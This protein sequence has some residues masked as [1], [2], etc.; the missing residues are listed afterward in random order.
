MAK[1][2]NLTS[3]A[4]SGLLQDEE[5]TRQATLQNRE[6]I[7]FLL[8]LHNHKCEEFEGLCCMNLTSKAGDVQKVIDQM[9]DMIKDIKRETGDWLENIFTSWGLSGWV[10]SVI[11]TGLLI[12]FVFILV[13]IAFSILRQIVS[14][15]ISRALNIPSVNQAAVLLV[16]ESTE[17]EE[18]YT[19]LEPKSGPWKET[20]PTCQPWFADTYRDLRVPSPSGI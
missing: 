8:L 3:T 19:E 7:D 4:L 20:A 17:E 6:V 5:I 18:N 16:Q 9:Q 14:N 2:A 13:L 11:R 1:H 10:T 15:L 12:L